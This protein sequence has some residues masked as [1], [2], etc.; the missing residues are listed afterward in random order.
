MEH[1]LVSQ[2]DKLSPLTLLVLGIAYTIGKSMSTNLKDSKKTIDDLEEKI[3][4]LKKELADL[5]EERNRYDK[6]KTDQ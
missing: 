5:R 4:D 3:D 2:L 6:K 1:D